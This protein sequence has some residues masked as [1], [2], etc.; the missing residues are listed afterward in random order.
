MESEI[1]QPW[2]QQLHSHLT[3]QL[4]PV[5]YRKKHVTLPKHTEIISWRMLRETYTFFQ[6]FGPNQTWETRCCKKHV[7]WSRKKCKQSGYNPSNPL[8]LLASIRKNRWEHPFYTGSTPRKGLI[9]G[10]CRVALSSGIQYV[11]FSG[12]FWERIF[13]L[14]NTLHGATTSEKLG[15]SQAL[16]QRSNSSQQ[17]GVL[18]DTCC[19]GTPMCTYNLSWN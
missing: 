5:L 14:L 9:D 6:R 15:Q 10:T 7:L 13:S 16:A 17:Q 1:K 8:I 2:Q 19:I 11:L 3:H 4:V 18:C 12:K